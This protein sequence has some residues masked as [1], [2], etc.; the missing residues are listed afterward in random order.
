MLGRNGEVADC[1]KCNVQSGLDRVTIMFAV[2]STS[3]CVVLLV[4]GRLV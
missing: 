2:C 4:L 3:M 1:V